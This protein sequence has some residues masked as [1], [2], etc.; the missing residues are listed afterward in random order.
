MT[1]PSLPQE[2]YQSVPPMG[3][4]A[5]LSRSS[6]RTHINTPRKRTVSVR[7]SNWRQGRSNIQSASDILRRDTIDWRRAKLPPGQKS[8]RETLGSLP[9]FPCKFC[10]MKHIGRIC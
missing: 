7:E 3:I 6:V 1:T 10:Q 2:Q 5:F 9:K 8:S 4:S